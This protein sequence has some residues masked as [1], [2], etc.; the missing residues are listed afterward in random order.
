MLNGRET[1]VTRLRERSR[2]PESRN[3]I[4]SP[5]CKEK[6]TLGPVDVSVRSKERRA[7]VPGY[8]VYNPIEEK[9]VKRI[10]VSDTD[11]L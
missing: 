4:F 10:S 9:G 5:R 2:L 6:L 3:E 1:I 11:F 7:I 8:R